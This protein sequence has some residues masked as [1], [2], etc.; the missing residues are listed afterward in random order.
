MRAI[1]R[2]PGSEPPSGTAALHRAAALLG[3]LL[4]AAAAC[5]GDGTPAWRAPAPPD[6][7]RLFA[8]DSL[9][10]PESVAWDSARGRY[11]VTNVSGEPSAEDGNGFVTAVSRSGDSVRRRAVTGEDLG[12]PLNAPKGIAVRGDRAWIADLRRVVGIDL[13]ADT[14]LFALR[15]E[16]SAF[17]NDVAAGRG[18]TVY[19]S[20]TERDAVYAV[21]ADGAGFPPTRLGAAGSLWSVNGIHPDPGAPGLLVAGWEGAVLRLAPDSSVT[22]LADPIDAENLDGVQPAGGDRLLY[23]DFSRGTLH[24][25]HRRRPGHWNPSRPW[26]EGLDGPADFLRHGDRLAVPEL[27]GDRV[28]WYRVSG[29][30]DST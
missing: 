15:V 9:R 23:T 11:L 3:G 28:V 13:R 19:V 7:T 1:A 17:L 8:V 21:P 2:P 26:L 22:L 20:D 25:L 10:S 27:E 5:G 6:V 4:V 16:G 29:R 12:V 14:A 18:D 24:A 30:R